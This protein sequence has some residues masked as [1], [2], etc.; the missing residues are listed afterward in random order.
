MAAAGAAAYCWRKIG[1]ARCRVAVAEVARGCWAVAELGL[2]FAGLLR[3]LRGEARLTQEELAEA[4]GLSPRSVSDLERGITRTTHKDTALLLAGALGLAEPVRALFVLA[5]RGRGPAA[6][7]LAARQKVPS[8]ARHNLPAPLTSFVGREQDL[9]RLEGLL[10]QARLVTLTGAGGAGKT[11]LALECASGVLGRFPD[12]V[13]LA[14]L[15]GISDPGLV[16]VAVMEALGV[17]QEGGLS[18]LEALGY[19][20]RSVDLL[21]VLDNCEH[22]LDACAELAG[23][24]LRGAPGLRVLATSREPLGVPGEV[25]YLVPPL[26]LP[27]ESADGEETGAA[28]AVRLFLDRAAA[29]RGGAAAD[30]AL[31]AA[32]RICRTLDGLPLA[33]ELAAARMGTLSATEIEAHLADRFAFLAYRRPVADPRHQALRVALDWSYELLTAEER[34][35]FDEL[36][37]FA[38]SFGLAQLADVCAAGDEAA[39]LEV[40]DRLAAK[41][42]LTAD[43]AE[44]GTRY[45][46]LETLRE[47]A[48]ARL[49]KAGDADAARQRHAV[50]FLSLA[51]QNQGLAVLSRDHDNFRSALDWSLS[52]GDELGPR[53]ALALGGFWLARGLLQEGREW[54]ER[55][56]AQSLADQ[57]LRAGLLRLLG[58]VLYEAGELNQAEAALADGAEAAAAAGATGERARIQVMLAEIHN[59][60]GGSNAVALEECQAATA[61]LE[62]EGDLQ[63]LAEAWLFAA[64]LQ[65]ND[66]GWSPEQQGYERAIA[67]ARQSGNHRVRIQ[68]SFWLAKE[69]STLPISAD[70]AIARVERLLHDAGGDRWAEAHLLMVLSV[71]YG[72]AG[73]VADA[74]AALARSRTLF[75]RFGGR[76]ALAQSAIPAGYIELAVADFVAAE[77]CFREGYEAFRVMGERGFRS[78]L[79]YQLA[80]ALYAQGRFDEAQ[81]MTEEAES[82]ALPDDLSP[83]AGWQTVRAKLLARRGQFP[84]ARRLAD[85][86][87]ALLGPTSWP[88]QK[89]EALVG[90]AE[91][92]RLAGDPDDAEH[93]LRAALALYEDIHTPPFA[94]QVKAALAS[95]TGSEVDSTSR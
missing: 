32:G 17:R 63:G 57:R 51:E 39:A 95:L 90:K 5:A 4:A 52:I 27:S 76:L 72:C 6:D 43:P 11:R 28:A 34:E 41:S 46:L 89:A 35:L 16:A 54:L 56:L 62:S 83:R 82:A 92:S 25:V 64:K 36:S 65:A 71:I 26:A 13:W 15:A 40:I 80:E 73:R 69:L 42:M 49:A 21:L 87:V 22:L 53:L 84:E 85:E 75:T 58:T 19:R 81:Q 12:G 88:V 45:R 23:A 37:V 31:V 18:V 38:G 67:Y 86:A 14:D 91:V 47:Y 77:R 68:A 70:A 7:V 9:A 44:G 59:D 55:A 94:E 20:L 30:V 10:G 93:C 60:L 50:A 33:I 61:V 79:A 29:A 3:Q 78:V 74:R 24:L 48:A 8:P 2:S 66:G 1:S